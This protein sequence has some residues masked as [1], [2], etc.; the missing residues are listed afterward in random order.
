MMRIDRGTSTKRNTMLSIMSINVVL[1]VLLTL[2][3]FDNNPDC[4]YYVQY[5]HIIFMYIARHTD[6]M[7]FS[8]CYYQV[9][10]EYGN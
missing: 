3:F 2:A 1:F 10:I 6:L 8:K 5:Y 4:T 9:P 7:S